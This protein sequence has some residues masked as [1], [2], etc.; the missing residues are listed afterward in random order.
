M[1]LYMLDLRALIEHP[2]QEPVPLKNEAGDLISGGNPCWSPDG[3]RI[4]FHDGEGVAIVNPDGSGYRLVAAVG[5]RPREPEWSPDGG[6]IVFRSGM[7]PNS[8]L[9]LI[10]NIDGGGEPE[11]LQLTGDA[12]WREC[13][14]HWSPDGRMIVFTRTQAGDS[15]QSGDVWVMDVATGAERRLT[16]TPSRRERALGWSPFDGKLYYE[17]SGDSPGSERLLVRMEADGS[18]IEWFQRAVMPVGRLSWA[19]AGAWIEG[20]NALPGERVVAKLGVQ[21]AEA[22]VEAG[23]DIFYTGGSDTVEPLG[24]G[25]GS[26]ILDWVMRQPQAGDGV[27]SVEAHVTDPDGQAVSGPA[28]LFELEFGNRSAAQPDDLQVLGFEGLHLEDR[29]GGQAEGPALAGGVRTIPFAALELMVSNKWVYG[30]GDVALWVT[31]RALDRNGE[32]M[33]DCE[34]PIRLGTYLFEAEKYWAEQNEVTPAR[35]DTVTLRRGAWSGRVIVPQPQ[36]GAP[37]IAYWGDIAAYSDP[38]TPKQEG[39]D[40]SVAARGSGGGRGGGQVA[41]LAEPTRTEALEVLSNMRQIGLAVH[42]FLAEHDEV[43]PGTNEIEKLRDILRDYVRSQSVFMRPGTD[44]VV[45]EFKFEPGTKATSV[46]R[47]SESVLAVVDYHPDWRALAYLDGHGR[48]DPKGDVVARYREA[49]EGG[50]AAFQQQFVF[51]A[52]ARRVR[53]NMQRLALAMRRYLNDHDGIFP[54]GRDADQLVEALGP[55]VTPDQILVHAA[56]GDPLTVRYLLP[57]GAAIPPAEAPETAF[58]EAEYAGARGVRVVAYADGH[59][60]IKREDDSAGGG[61]GGWG[62]VGMVMNMEQFAL[63][64]RDYL[65][66]HDDKAPPAGDIRTALKALAPYLEPKLLFLRPGTRDEVVQYVME[67][68]TRWSDLSGRAAP[69][70]RVFLADFGY[71]FLLVVGAD[72]VARIELKQGAAAP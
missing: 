71:E 54:R 53:N 40:E 36:P 37:L 52:E 4:A 38:L 58:A 13:W 51:P 57:S 41:W 39:R 20:V 5:I 26:S 44:E 22:L 59:M 14:P 30:D 29:W 48:L 72:M 61:G 33:A 11:V 35:P 10:T 12:D 49:R 45:V 19:R 63:V 62:L 56:S 66:D 9:F 32:V 7:E 16:D 42:M 3:R 50:A 46:E 34:N 21:D 28:H 65:A 18:G 70:R 47:P 69:D 27:V 64:M 55:Y 6:A 67:P 23:A 2:G 24:V 8:H 68:G 1:F 17:E 60:E 15:R 25:R 43:L 31:V